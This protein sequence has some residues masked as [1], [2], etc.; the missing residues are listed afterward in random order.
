M[1]KNVTRVSFFISKDDWEK[2]QE[3][4]QKK[5]VSASMIV[6]QLIIDFMKKEKV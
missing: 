4:S 2:L 6:R 5:Q 3:Y 1:I